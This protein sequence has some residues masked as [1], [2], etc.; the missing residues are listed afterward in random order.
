VEIK[1]VIDSPEI[2][3]LQQVQTALINKQAELEA[4]IIALEVAGG[5][6]PPEP[7]PTPAP[8]PINEELAKIT[9]RGRRM[10]WHGVNVAWWEWA[11][12]FGATENGWLAQNVLDDSG[13]LRLN[14]S[15]VRR[16]QPVKD[17]GCNVVTWWMFPGESTDTEQKTPKQ[18]LP[19]EDGRPTGLAPSVYKDLD[20]AIKIARHFGFYLNMALFSQPHY[21]PEWWF[22][23]PVVID[24]LKPLFERYANEP[25]L[26]CWTILVEPEWAIQAHK[27][28]GSAEILVPWADRMIEVIRSLSPDKLITINSAHVDWIWPWLNTDLDFHSASWYDD[29]NTHSPTYGNPLEHGGHVPGHNKWCAL[30]QTADQVREML[31]VEKPIVIGEYYAGADASYVPVAGGPD[32]GVNGRV[33]AWYD[34][35][36]AGAMA[37]SLFHEKTMT[38]MPIHWPALAAFAAGHSDIGPEAD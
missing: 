9:Y 25:Q 30:C 8:P 18:F 31:M 21:Y 7:D 37:W 27:R 11:N 38:P 16:F 26:M 36:Y 3:A 29:K 4:R 35:G 28:N 17:A 32:Q 2:E 34:K 20:A 1:L 10:Y 23:D 19:D 5:Q 22:T 12:D 14:S 13:E 24:L 33:Q 6:T 15:V